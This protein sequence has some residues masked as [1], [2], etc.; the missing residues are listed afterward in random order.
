MGALSGTLAERVRAALSAGCEL[1]LHCNG[2]L[3]EMAEVAEAA[4]LLNSATKARIERGER[5]RKL[6]SE[7][8]LA[9]SAARLEAILMAA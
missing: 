5:M 6:D 2:K 9:A 8:D 7:F 1:A 3:D 4:G